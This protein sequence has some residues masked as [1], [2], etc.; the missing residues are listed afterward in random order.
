V[1]ATVI[2]SVA[3]SGTRAK[4][5]DHFGRRNETTKRFCG[6]TAYDQMIR[7][8]LQRIVS[9]AGFAVCVISQKQVVGYFDRDRRT[10][11]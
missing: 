11:K 6:E 5:V 8:Q 1:K 10:G 4:A 7:F 3:R 9:A 2:I